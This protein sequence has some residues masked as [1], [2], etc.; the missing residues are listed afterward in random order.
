MLQTG[1]VRLDHEIE[2]YDGTTG[3]LVACVRIP[4]LPAANTTIFICYGASIV[5]YVGH[6]GTVV[7][8]SENFFNYQD[9]SALALQAQQPFL[10][11]ANCLNGFFQFPPMDSLSEALLKAPGKGVIGAFSPTGLS[12]DE[13]A[14][15]FHEALLQEIVS[16]EHARLGDAVLAAQESYAQA[17]VFPELLSVYHLLGDPATTI[18]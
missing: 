5:S 1:G 9:V 14:H 13:P 11:T 8:A 12:V 7:W 4:S 10:V 6:G 16:G 17:G 15:R 18:R 3:T 2:R